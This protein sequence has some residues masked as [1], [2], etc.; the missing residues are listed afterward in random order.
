MRTTA[1]SGWRGKNF[2]VNTQTTAIPLHGY[3]QHG[4]ELVGVQVN[5][6]KSFLVEKSGVLQITEI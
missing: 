2:H 3:A 6:V 5:A 4:R 1:I